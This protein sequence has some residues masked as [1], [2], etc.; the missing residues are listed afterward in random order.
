MNNIPVEF[1]NGKAII[2]IEDYELLVGK[3]RDKVVEDN[4]RAATQER[5]QYDEPHVVDLKRQTE[6]E[7]SEVDQ[8]KVPAAIA[9]N[10]INPGKKVK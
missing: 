7:Q 5:E 3:E 9:S 1:R 10:K 2:S 4:D 6:D 8:S